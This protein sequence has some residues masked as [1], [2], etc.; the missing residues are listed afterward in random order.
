MGRRS[1]NVGATGAALRTWG[2]DN[3]RVRS[4][5]RDSSPAP[6]AVDPP[7]LGD[8]LLMVVAIGAVS[9]AAPLITAAAAP[10]L[11]IAFWRNAMGS[12]AVLPMA[13]AGA[14]GELAR[15]GTRE[16]A[17]AIGAGALL[18]AH[19]GTWIPSLAFTTVASATALTATQPVWA[20]LIGRMRGERV[21]AL[22]WLGIAAAVTGTAMLTG[23][24]VFFSGHALAG[25]VLAL[26][27]GL[28]GAAYVTVGSRVRRGV[29]TTAYTALCYP[30]AALVLLIA[31]LGS[32]APLVG[33]DATT[34]L[35]IAGVTVGPQ[36]LG[37]SL[38]NRVLRNTSATIVSL[39]MLLEVPGA[40][41]IAAL[42]LG[43][44]P[45]YTAIPA[46]L[47]L[48]GGVAVVVRSRQSG[49]AAADTGK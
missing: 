6:S 39:G 30:V 22:A 21:P 44:V 20:A 43:E 48:L 36:L 25:D 28:F 16:R 31:C 47:L 24:D 17:L 42:W 38:F 33:Y 11:A 18:A 46:V 34:W 41:L 23:V 45:P 37:H 29:S 2:R 9:T 35:M 7:P 12:A 4:Y 5:G 19:F 27:G 26:A 13:L 40:A 3:G 32:G 15:M 8:L 14:R 49:P 10:T 1:Q